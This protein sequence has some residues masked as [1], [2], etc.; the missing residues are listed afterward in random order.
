MRMTS[1][2]P[3]MSRKPPSK[4]KAMNRN[5]SEPSWTDIHVKR[6]LLKAVLNI[7][8]TIV[9][10]A[11]T[12]DHIAKSTAVQMAFIAVRFVVMIALLPIILALSIVGAIAYGVVWLIMV[13]FIAIFGNPFDNLEKT[14]LA[15]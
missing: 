10:V 8:V 6:K 13:A 2:F 14:F 5:A 12:L 9:I 1:S 15:T 4:D 3:S 7:V 11:D